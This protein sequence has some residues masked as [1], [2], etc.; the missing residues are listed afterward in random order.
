MQ[1]IKIFKGIRSPAVIVSISVT[2]DVAHEDKHNTP[3]TAAH[4]NIKKDY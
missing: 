3:W 2:T 4:V 1:A